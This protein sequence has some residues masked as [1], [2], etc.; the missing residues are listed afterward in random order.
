MLMQR[1]RGPIAVRFQ[2]LRPSSSRRSKP[3]TTHHQYGNL[4]AAYV[5]L[6]RPLKQGCGPYGIM[7][8]RD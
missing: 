5:V 6:I 7:A 4:E 1:F 8:R 3:S 2:T